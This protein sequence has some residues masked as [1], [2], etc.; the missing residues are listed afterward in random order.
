[1]CA[2]GYHM[3]AVVWYWAGISIGCENTRALSETPIE[4]TKPPGQ[5]TKS[6]SSVARVIYG[7]AK[8]CNWQ[9]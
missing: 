6:H 2:W 5:A 8:L 4:A 7:K 1:M 3:E 9:G